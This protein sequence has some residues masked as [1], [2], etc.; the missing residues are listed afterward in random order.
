MRCYGECCKDSEH[1]KTC[2]DRNIYGCDQHWHSDRDSSWVAC[3][4]QV[5]AAKASLK[6]LQQDGPEYDRLADRLHQLRLA[7][8]ERKF[9]HAARLRLE[10]EERAL[11][12]VP[13][14]ER[15]K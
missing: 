2:S 11:G 13:V 4:P 10:A 3:Q 8:Y 1:E 14:D 7:A 15:D 5:Q 6:L 12:I 9:G